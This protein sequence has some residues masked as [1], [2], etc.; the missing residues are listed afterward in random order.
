MFEPSGE[1]HPLVVPEGVDELITFFRVNGMMLSV[2]SWGKVQGYEDV[3][4]KIDLFK[5]HFKAVRLGEDF[6][7]QLVR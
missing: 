7:Y 6:M 2:D 3:F 4:S 5:T 1:T